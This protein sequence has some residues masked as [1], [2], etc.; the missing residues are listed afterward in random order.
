MD[1]DR[2]GASS[3]G[4]LMASLKALG[5]VWIVVAKKIG[6]VQAYVMMSLVYF[7]FMAPFALAS[8]A[9]ADPLALGASPGWHPV[10]PSGPADLNSVRLQY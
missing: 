3:P 6:H 4:P 5:R 2:S 9:F 10:T 8:R 1:K 7:V